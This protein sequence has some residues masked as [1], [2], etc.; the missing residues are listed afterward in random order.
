MWKL[1]K[2]SPLKSSTLFNENGFIGLYFTFCLFFSY[3]TQETE[4]IVNGT[5][6]QGN[7]DFAIMGSLHILKQ[8]GKM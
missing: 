4:N 6:L 7:M 1:I 2:R 3:Y 5:F 8:K